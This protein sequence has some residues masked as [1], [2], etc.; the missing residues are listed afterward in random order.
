MQNMTKAID[1]FNKMFQT[2]DSTSLS[3][4]VI[5]QAPIIAQYGKN[6]LK[7]YPELDTKEDLSEVRGRV[8]AL[9]L[10]YNRIQAEFA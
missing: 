4:M 9:E 7:M 2:F 1:K 10:G 5:H 8:A 6:L 3:E